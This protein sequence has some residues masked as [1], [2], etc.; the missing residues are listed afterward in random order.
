MQWVDDLL[1]GYVQAT[2]ELPDAQPADDEGPEPLVGTIVRS[3]QAPCHRT[4]LLYTHGWNDYFFQ[5]HLADFVNERLG[6]DFYAVDVRRNGRSLRPGQ[7]ASYVT[8]MDAYA[9]EFDAALDVIRGE[10]HDQ[11]VLMGHSTGGLAMTL[12]AD[13]Q[14]SGLVA[15]ILNSPFLATPPVPGQAALAPVVRRIGAR[16]PTREIPIDDVAEIYARALHA[17]YGGEWDWDMKLKQSPA[18]RLRF[19]WL[20]AALRAQAMVNRGLDVTVPILCV[21]AGLSSIQ[22]TYSDDARHTDVVLDQKRVGRAATRLGNR[23]T[24]VRIPDGVHDLA[25]SAHGPR[26]VYFDEIERWLGYA[27]PGLERH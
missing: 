13:R 6:L 17:R 15:L 23:V 12:Y 27:D 1:P 19:G 18:P 7:H 25:L 20:R 22:R 11:F 10:G 16:H 2:L 5:T 14:P 3:R 8:D 9:V 24:I 4:A 26:G 21:T